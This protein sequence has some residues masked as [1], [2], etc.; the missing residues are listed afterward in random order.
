MDLHEPFRSWMR[1]IMNETDGFIP[2]KCQMVLL[3]EK[4]KGRTRSLKRIVK[5]LFFSNNC[6]LL[7]YTLTAWAAPGAFIMAETSVLI[8]VMGM[9]RGWFGVW[10]LSKHRIGTRQQREHQSALITELSAKEG[11]VLMNYTA[12]EMRQN[13]HTHKLSLHTLWLSHSCMHT[14]SLLLTQIR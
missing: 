8:R 6:P 11:S 4:N 2:E 10:S 1:S 13:P 5:C 7:C 12:K 14:H 3:G 9:L